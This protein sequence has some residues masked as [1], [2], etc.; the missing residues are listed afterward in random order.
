MLMFGWDFLLMLSR[1]CE[2]E[3]WSK[4]VFELVT[5]RQEVTLARWT[6][7]SGPLCLWQCLTMNWY[8]KWKRVLLWWILSTGTQL[9]ICIFRDTGHM[10]KWK[11]ECGYHHIKVRIVSWYG[12]VMIMGGEKRNVQLAVN[13]L[14]GSRIQ[15]MTNICNIIHM[16]GLHGVI[17]TDVLT[18]WRGEKKRFAPYNVDLALSPIYREAGRLFQI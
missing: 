11:F 18:R 13:A 14:I 2:D 17:Q 3:M 9:D 12:D 7:P 1:D 16:N 4:F 10:I 8:W 5:W 6:Q 15:A